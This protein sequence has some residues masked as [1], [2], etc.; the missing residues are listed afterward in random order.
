[1]AANVFKVLLADW[2]IGG[3]LTLYF[4]V[5]YVGDWSNLRLME[6]ATYDLRSFLRAHGQQSEQIEMVAVDQ[7]S[8]N[9][10]GRWPWPRATQARLIENLR[11][12]GAK[13]IVFDFSMSEPD[14]SSQGLE[15]M[16]AL[17][18]R[19]TAQIASP[20]TDA[21]QREFYIRELQSLNESEARLDQDAKFATMLNR[22]AEVILPLSFE[23]GRPEGAESAEPSAAIAASSFSLI[24]N[25]RD[26]ASY[27]P[28]KVRKMT[29]PLPAFQLPQVGFGHTTVVPD[30]DNIVRRDVVLVEYLDRFYPSLA[31]RALS[32][33]LDVA[34]DDVHV[35]LGKG[36]KIG[37]LWVPTD[38]YMRTRTSFSGPAGTFKPFSA[39]HVLGGKIPSNTFRGKLVL[40]GP[41]A[42]TA[43]A[44]PYETPTGPATTGLEVTA[45]VIQN[46]LTQS[47]L[48]VPR[49]A[50]AV[51]L[52][53]ILLIGVFVVLALPRLGTKWSGIVAGTILASYL[54]FVVIMYASKGYVLTVV[55]PSLMLILAYTFLAAK[56]ALLAER[57]ASSDSGAS[58]T[59]RMLGL[60]FQGQGMLE[61][62]FDKFKACPIDDSMKE[63]LYNLGQDFERKRMPSKALSAYQHIGTKDK[64]YKDIEQRMKRLSAAES[65]G[66]GGKSAGSGSLLAEGS[67]VKPTLGRYEIVKELGRGAMGI[68]YLG[69]DPKIHRSVAIK[70]MRLDE[71]E[72]DEIQD[73]KSRFFREAESAGKLS[74]PNIVT[75]YDAGEE[76]DLAYFAME[77]LDGVDLKDLCKKR[78]L[79]PVKRTLEI[80]AKV[81]E[82]LDYAHSQSV[83]HRD[84]KPANIMVMPDG[85][86]KVTDFGIARVTTSAKTQT[87]IVLGT[88]SYMSPEQLSG[89]KVDGR[90]DLFSLGIVL[91]EMLTGERPFQGE[92]V[93]TLMYVIANQ[94]HPS[95]FD[96][97]PDLPKPVGAVIDRALQKDATKRYQR[98]LEM[99]QDIRALMQGLTV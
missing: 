41:M 74:H 69:K 20:Q 78:N 29:A 66:A 96:L 33:Y 42:A 47:S 38:R 95:P 86:V 60:T 48:T 56:R 82:A 17:R 34:P 1:M 94:P 88:P 10:V 28:L 80:V 70:T 18:Q 87:G 83:V 92:S 50:P 8:L 63:L 54:G 26:M 59:N 55:H 24:D 5:G 71:V 75:I 67:D 79:L 68:V 91:F 90:S 61:L 30:S 11:A 62:A 57:G 45:N 7:E 4:L 31:L 43:G 6:N 37:D 77:V 16:R 53:V 84:I 14:R 39:H 76:Q 21:R 35:A 44:V 49:W 46:M 2:M 9:K 97:R 85:A 65:A 40:V 12:G 58:E 25:P 22:S 51:E 13:V 15:E 99:A 36:V 32:T 93:A 27:P 23:L 98:G 64:H 19:Y 73:V 72:A 89:A 3:I 81:A 52:S